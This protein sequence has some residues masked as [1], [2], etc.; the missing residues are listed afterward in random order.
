MNINLNEVNRDDFNV[1]PGEI[2]G[3]T[4]YL[5]FPKMFPKWDNKNRYFRSSIWNKGGEL[6]SASWRKFTNHNGEQPDFEPLP[7][8]GVGG[9]IQK[10]DGSTLIVSKY[11]NELIVRTRGSFNTE[12]Q[13]NKSD[14]DLFKVK[15]PDLFDNCLIN[16]GKFSIVCEWVSPRNIIV[17]KELPEP[18]LFLTG[19]IHHKDYWYEGQKGLDILAE[20]MLGLKRPRY[21]PIKDNLA[22]TLSGIEKM[23]EIEG[24]VIFSR[25]GQILKKVKTELYLRLHRFRNSATLEST[26]DLFA[27]M[28]YPTYN[29]FEK[30]ISELYDF[31]CFQMIRGHASLICDAHKEVNRIIEGMKVFL[32]DRKGFGRKDLALDVVSSYGKTNRASFLFL[33]ADKGSLGSDSLKK[34]FWQVLKKD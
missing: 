7:D 31:E 25:D 13:E 12:S 6:I 3:E 5:I 4:C 17:L 15:Y 32:L 14:I 29:E 22:Q 34:L 10:I 18:D 27:E 2:A 1:K 23:T 8:K 20:D 26:L 28:G 33:L 19:L 9:L 24:V 21:F 30:R 16:D 11:K